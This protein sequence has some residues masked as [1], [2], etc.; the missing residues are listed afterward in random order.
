MLKSVGAEDDF[1]HPRYWNSTPVVAFDWQ[2]MTSYYC[3]V[4]TF[5]QG[6]TVVE[7]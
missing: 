6:E 3:S 4:V 7:L 2:G 5:G 1:R